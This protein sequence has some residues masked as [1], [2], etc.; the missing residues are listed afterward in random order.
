MFCD[1]STVAKLY[2]NEVNS[3]AVR[4]QLEAAA[5]VY[6]SEFAR[7]ELH[8]VFHRRYRE[9]LWTSVDFN[10]AVQQFNHDDISGFWTWLPLDPAV[11][12]AAAKIFLTLSPD[13]YLRSAD[14]IHL[15]TAL[16]NNFSDVYTHDKHQIA[17]AASLGLNPIAIG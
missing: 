7:V 17:A 14:C 4:R 2:V 6:L 9:G 1:T 10:A 13:I 15:V 5:A 16:Q 3:P 11:V 12:G 8:A